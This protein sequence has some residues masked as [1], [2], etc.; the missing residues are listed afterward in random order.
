M[1]FPAL[2]T[3]C[4]VLLSS[5]NW[6]VSLFIIK[7][8]VNI[9]VDRDFWLAD[10][11][12][13]TVK[14]ELTFY[15]STWKWLATIKIRT[16]KRNSQTSTYHWHPSLP[17]YVLGKYLFQQFLA[18][19]KQWNN[20]V[21]LTKRKEK[22]EKKKIICYSLSRRPIF[23]RSVVKSI[24]LFY[25]NRVDK[26]KEMKLLRCLIWSINTDFWNLVSQLYS[27]FLFRFRVIFQL[28]TWVSSVF[29]NVVKPFS[30]FYVA[31]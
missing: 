6:F 30:L 7:W 13:R 14:G 11:K 1:F 19:Q 12:L 8:Q 24:I 4:M 25:S 16:Q 28:S 3:D 17:N 29:R 26:L 9:G 21:S 31:E 5:S 10:S 18:L 15:V 27:Y 22:Y 23:V 20:N 2:F